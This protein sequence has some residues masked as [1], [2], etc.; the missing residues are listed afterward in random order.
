MNT[1]K[2][3]V[4][5]DLSERTYDIEIAAGNLSS[6]GRFVRSRCDAQ[7]AIV[8][9]DEHVEFPHAE[10]VGNSLLES[11]MDVDILIAEA[12]EPSK[13]VTVAEGMWENLV[14]LGTDRK[15]DRA[16]RW[17]RR[18]RRPGWIRRGHVCTGNFVLS[19]SHDAPG[20]SRQQRRR[21]S[22]N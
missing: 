1:D 14:D 16:G 22:R 19:S 21:E 3:I 12:G 11:D 9:T 13:S 8:I 17:R 6:A 7:Y 18:D 10:A 4:H 2:T 5:V 20:T 15:I